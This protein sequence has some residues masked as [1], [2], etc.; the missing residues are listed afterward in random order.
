MIYC[1]IQ[2]GR[3]FGVVTTDSALL[4]LYQ[5]GDISYDRALSNARRPED[6]ERRAS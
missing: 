2:A 6:I 3:R 4:Q 5:D 1:E